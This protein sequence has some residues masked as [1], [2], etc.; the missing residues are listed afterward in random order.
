[1]FFEQTLFFTLAE[2][3]LLK[4]HSPLAFTLYFLRTEI[5]YIAMG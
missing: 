3:I 2:N 1:M 5:H 4:A